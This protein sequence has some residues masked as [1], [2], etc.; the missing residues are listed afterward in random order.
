MNKQGKSSGMRMMFFMMLISIVIAFL[1]NHI[2]LIKQTIH[3]I[4]NPTAGF[5]LSINANL[6]MIIITAIISLAISLAQKYTIDHASLSEIK[7]E[8]KLLAEEMK[9]YKNHPE[10][11][12][13][14]QKKQF[15]FIPRTME[16]TLKPAIYTSIPI[17][18]FFRW[19]QD[20]F[21]ANPVKILGF[22]SWF[23]PYLIFSIIFSSIFRRVLKLDIPGS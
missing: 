9:K 6:G 12:L 1:W 15:A 10:K 16:I 21:T 7:K 8:Q 17:I 11:L 18:L 14:L 22:S 2:P 13:E 23:W 20:Y 5:L 4:L 3:F 19:F